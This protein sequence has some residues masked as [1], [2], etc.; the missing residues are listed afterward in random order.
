MPPRLLLQDACVLINLL[1]SGRFEDIARAC[2][3]QFVIA[4]AVRAEALYIR[5]GTTGEPMLID[6]EPH[7]EAGRL[8]EI[9]VET[10]AERAAYVTYAAY[11]DDGEAMSLALAEARQLPLA[12]DDRK[13]RALVARESISVELSSTVGVLQA[14]EANAAIQKPEMKM[15]L[16]RIQTC[17]RFSPSSRTPDGRWWDERIHA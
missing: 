7:L 13:A 8:E 14:W 12:T 16:A 11:L 17:A 15:V 5:D 4:S 2:G 10:E 3:F 6:L 9:R 1:A